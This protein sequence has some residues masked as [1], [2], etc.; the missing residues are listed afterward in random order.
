MEN[1]EKFEYSG[2]SS[3]FPNLI[4]PYLLKARTK[5]KTTKK[6]TA[7]SYIHPQLETVAESIRS[8]TE[9]KELLSKAPHRINP[10]QIIA[11]AMNTVESKRPKIPQLLVTSFL[12]LGIKSLVLL[13]LLFMGIL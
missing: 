9:D 13:F 1:H 7:V 4:L 2:T 11:E 8:N 5:Q 3:S 12:S 10:K 6:S